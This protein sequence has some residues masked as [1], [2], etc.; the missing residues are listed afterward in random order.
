MGSKRVSKGTGS[1]IKGLS[2]VYSRGAMQEKS[3]KSKEWSEAVKKSANPAYADA[4]GFTVRKTTP[5][6]HAKGI[7]AQRLSD[8]KGM[9]KWAVER[10]QEKLRKQGYKG[11]FR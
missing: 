2:T 4:A 10:S 5:G 7:S 6:E 11:K 1:D 3:M 8:D 9:G